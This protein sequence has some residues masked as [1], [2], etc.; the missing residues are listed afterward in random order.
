MKPN[1]LYCYVRTNPFTADWSSLSQCYQ[2]IIGLDGFALYHYLHAFVDYGQGRY[3]FSRILNHLDFG[4]PRL[5]R[6]LDVLEAVD[7]LERY[8]MDGAYGLL[9]KPPLSTQAFLHKPLYRQL[10]TKK[11]GES[12]LEQLRLLRPNQEQNITKRFSDVFTIE[13][14][15]EMQVQG[16]ATSGLDWQAFKSMMARDKLRFQQETDDMIALEYLAEQEGWNWLE[17]Y[18]K[19]KETALDQMISTKRLAQKIQGHH[20]APKGSLTAQEAALARESKTM[21]ALEFLAFLKESR[22]AAVTASERK[23]LKDMAVLGLLDEVINVLV[24]YSLNKLDSAN[25]N[26]KYALKLANDFSYKGIATAEAAILYLREQRT[27]SKLQKPA[28]E[29]VSNVPEWSKKEVKTKT[30][31]EGKAKMDALRRQMLANENKG[32]GS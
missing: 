3:K 26:E 10:L 1:D 9:V 28:Q 19:A 4:M 25:L 2:P 30:S 8:Q 29:A 6:A 15:V 11:I 31:A 12:A 16:S 22:K 7:L 23:C 5:E 18:Q 27:S 13:G 24:L 20:Q 17:L 14:K 32:G 21:T